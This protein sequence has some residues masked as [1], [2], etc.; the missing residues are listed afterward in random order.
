[1]ILNLTYFREWVSIGTLSEIVQYT[2][3]VLLLVKMS[4]EFKFSVRAVAELF[5]VL[6]M[7]FVGYSCG[8]LSFAVS[9]ALVYS[10]K[11]V[12]FEKVLQLTFVIQAAF[13]IVTVTSSQLGI[14]EDYIWREELR[15]RHGLGYTHCLLG[16]HFVLFMSLILLA[17]FKKLKVWLALLIV[18]AN[19]LIYVYTDGRTNLMLAAGMILLA[20]VAQ[21]AEK[22]LKSSRV[23]ALGAGIIPL[24][25][26]AAGVYAA[27]N[28]SFESP[29]W[30]RLNEIL[31][32]RIA[33]MFW[34][35]NEY[36]ATWFGQRI[37]WIGAS[38]LKD[39]PD[40][41]YNYVDNAYVQAF[42]SYGTVFAVLLCLGWGIV[43]YRTMRKGQYVMASVILVV[44]IHGLINPQMI[45]LAYNPFF[46]LL[47]TI[48]VPEKKITE[49]A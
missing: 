25:F 7:M 2:V 11:N 32:M 4:M 14:I 9:L 37:K 44:L 13:L 46:L 43:L 12:S 35:W 5:V 15:E 19:G 31:N 1:M 42:F 24:A 47:G 6:L 10:I 3:L 40:L 28:F 17:Y 29:V 26:G 22:Y 36:G 39:N 21:L 45:E 41:A 48:N 16:S 34:A 20:C 23:V 38:V 33:L 8:R 27:S 18:L 30:V 49:S